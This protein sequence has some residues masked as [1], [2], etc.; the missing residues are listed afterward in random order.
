MNKL[1]MMAQRR[2]QMAEQGHTSYQSTGATT[3]TLAN[4]GIGSGTNTKPNSRPN[5]SQG[6]SPSNPKLKG[7]G[8]V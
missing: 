6:Q 1:S 2:K 8:G 7:V 5:S 4:S 3:A